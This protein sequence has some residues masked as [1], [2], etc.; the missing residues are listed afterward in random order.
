MACARWSLPRPWARALTPLA[1]LAMG[2]TY[3]RGFA[4]DPVFSFTLLAL[5]CALFIA[6]T[7]GTLMDRGSGVGA[8]MAWA[9]A[10]LRWMGRHSY[11]LYLFHVIVL[12]G[13]RQ[14]ISKQSLTHDQR[15][16]LLLA[17][18]LVCA[19]L[20]GTIARDFSEPINRYWRLRWSSLP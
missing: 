6:A 8:L 19:V 18:L 15:L 13:L 4:D 14:F 11:E 2:A 10:P 5:S 20:A 12:A 17:F 9:S 3:V 7:R 1:A 16:P